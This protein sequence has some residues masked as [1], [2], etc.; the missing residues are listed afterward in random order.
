MWTRILLLLVCAC[1]A[2]SQNSTPSQLAPAIETLAVA[3]IHVDKHRFKSGEKIK[4]AILLE[5]GPFGVYIPKSWGQSGGGIPGFSVRMT[6]LSGNGAETCG[7]AGDAL[8]TS[9]PD[10]KVA[11]NRDFIYLSP[12]NFIGLKTSLNCP[13]KRP[14]KYLIDA[15]YSPYHPDGDRVAQLPETRGLVLR[16]GV[17]AKPVAISIY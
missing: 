9:E 5:S 8:R 1:S 17:H 3:S 13:T 12:H 2:S 4:V 6:T 14:G 7:L 10:A 16:T 11:L 15:W